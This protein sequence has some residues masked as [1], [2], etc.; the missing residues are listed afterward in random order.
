VTNCSVRSAADG[1]AESGY[2]DHLLFALPHSDLPA[3]DQLALTVPPRKRA[4]WLMRW[5][6]RRLHVR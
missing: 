3:V 5:T 2:L 6:A 1:H 4:R